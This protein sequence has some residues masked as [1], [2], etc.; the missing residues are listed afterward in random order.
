[1]SGRADI[2]GPVSLALEAELRER[3]R[4]H[5]VVLWLDLDDEFSAFAERLAEASAA[6]AVDYAVCRFRG[7]YLELMMAFE[8]HG[9]GVTPGRLLVH[10]PGFN[11]DRVRRTPLFELYRAGV[12]HRK[13]LDTLIG[14]VA[15]GKVRQ[16]EIEA[17]RAGDGVTLEMAD[18]W[19]RA[20]VEDPTGGFGARLRQVP[21]ATLVADLD[22]RGPIASQLSDAEHAGVVWNHFGA[23][24]GMPGDWPGVPAPTSGGNETGPGRDDGEGETPANPTAGRSLSP[25]RASADIAF[26]AAS[27]AL[28]VEYVDDL[29]RAPVAPVLSAARDLPRALVDA[30]R[31]LAEALRA[32]HRTFYERIAAEAEDLLHDEVAAA[33]AEDLGDIDTFRFEETRVLDDA[34]EGL[35]RQ[36]WSAAGDWARLRLDGR[37][38]WL[39]QEPTRASAWRLVE[40]AAT[41]GERIADAGPSLGNVSRL[42]DAVQRYAESGAPVDRAHRELEQQRHALLHPNV[43][44]FARLR[45]RLDALRE[46]WREWA[47]QWAVDFNRLCVARG[48]LPDAGWQQRMLFDEVVRPMTQEH[49]TT[50]YFVV[51]ALRYEM[52]TQLYESFRDMPATRVEL[53]ARLAELPSV[54]EVGMNVLAPV[55]RGGRLQ[56]SVASASVAGGGSFQGFSTG[57]FRVSTPETRRRA[58]HDRV[59]GPTCPLLT[60]DEVIERDAA[61][62]KGT[63]SKAKLVVVWATE[64]DDAGEK[65]V[66]LAVFESAIRRL[67][68][69]WRLLREAGVKRFVITADHGYLLL[70]DATSSARQHG[71][72]IDPKRRHVIK[73]VAE[74]GEGQVRVPMAELRYDGVAKHLV[75]PETTAIFDIGKRE[76]GFVHGGNSLQERVIPVLTVVH[77]ESQGGE[78]LA[79]RVD[80]TRRDAVAGMHAVRAKVVPDGQF[81]LGFATR[82]EVELTLSV[83]DPPGVRV[84][85]C[86]A[87]DGARVSAGAIVASVGAEFEVFF[88]LRG[89]DAA[90]AQV[91]LRHPGAAVELAPFVIAERFEVSVWEAISTES[92]PDAAGAGA[93]TADTAAAERRASSAGPTTWLGSL[94]DGGVRDVFAHIAA[95]GV[96]TEG[97][98]QS[99]LGSARLAR[100]F[101]AQF[102]KHAK[103]A[104]FRVTITVVGGVKRYVREG[105][106]T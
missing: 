85:V 54:T 11:E 45:A 62:L 61:A 41:L 77:R 46:A 2:G 100:R 4:S 75:M 84:E 92:L 30:C 105:A 37:S 56:P 83:V 31:Q 59:G 10:L 88:R 98:A 38:F 76:A 23:R 33:R 47:D 39:Q 82:S 8:A 15:S 71:R 36:A 96:I 89:P 35:E 26:A 102:E 28:A 87:R 27:W 94:P 49:G 51:D 80:A 12:R 60:V 99:L 21:L 65:G 101:A 106:Q 22:G 52:A 53:G 5:R 48:F 70:H 78:Q 68:A 97:E 1:M 66:G 24:L 57:E 16:E 69:V 73:D 7:S 58:M 43:P 91:E 9:G 93:G 17:F 20:I 81:S 29:R 32:Q 74:D 14:E 55:Q 40:A 44:E 25:T 86:D 104:P 13:R 95:H 42:E 34:I 50:A 103:K 63:V 67:R 72:K 64:I 90:R 3:V 6:G 79:Y 18:A 19:L